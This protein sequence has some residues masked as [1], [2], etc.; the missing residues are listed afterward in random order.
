MKTFD[1]AGKTWEYDNC[2]IF[3]LELGRYKNKYQPHK[4]FDD[5][6]TAISAYENFN[7]SE[8]YKKRFV[9]VMNGL[10][11]TISK[12]TTQRLSK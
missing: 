3:L 12:Q 11:T 2:T 5:I 9:R 8:G 4:E 6:L 10:Q 1:Y 7:V